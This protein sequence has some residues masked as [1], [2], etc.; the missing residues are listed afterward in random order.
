LVLLAALLVALPAMAEWSTQDARPVSNG[1]GYGENYIPAGTRFVVLLDDHLNSNRLEQGKTF[2]AKLGEDLT[3]PNGE[4]IPR[5][6]KVK[7]HV[8]SVSTGFDGRLLLSFDQIETQHGWVPLAATVT[9]IPGEHGIKTSNEGEVQRT[10]DKQRTAE[11]AVAGAAVGAGTGALAGGGRG[12]VIGA[13][14][15]GVVG[16]TAG[17]LTGRNINLNKGQQLELELDRPLQVPTH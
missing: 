9:D 14:V 13:A 15:G 5:G 17:L 6:K 7:G 8:S 1:Q 2:K 11:T 4:V 3:A 10:V 16:G 12:A